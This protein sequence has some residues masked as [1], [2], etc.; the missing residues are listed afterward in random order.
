M[1]RLKTF[2]LKSMWGNYNFDFAC[3]MARGRSGGLISMRDPNSFIKDDI[4]CDDTFIIVK[5][6][7]RNTVG[8]CYM[9]NIYGPQ[10]SLA[11]A[12]LWNRIGD[13]MHQ[14]AD[15][16][17]SF[18]D[19]SGLTDLPL[20]G[21]EV[22][23]ALLDVRVT[24]IDRLWS[25]HNLILLHVSKS[26]FGPTPFKLFH[27]L[28]L[29]DSFD[30]VIKIELSKLEEHNFGRKLLS[31]EK[32]R[33]LKVRKKRWHSET[34][35][36]DRVTKHD[37]LQLI[38][39][40]E[41]KIKAGSAN[42]DDYDSRIKLLQEVDILDTFESFDLLKKARVKWDIEGD[43]DSKFF[44]G[45]IKQKRIAQMIHERFKE[46]DLNVDFPLFVNSSGLCTLD[47]NSL[48]T[49]VSLDEVKNAV[50]DYGSSK[51]PSPDGFLFTFVKKY[52]DY[53][54][55]DIWSMSIFFLILVCCPMDLI[56]ISSLSFQRLAKVIDKIIDGPLILSEI[57][58]WFQKK[59]KK[60]LI[61]KIDFE[62]A[63]DS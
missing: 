13:F 45:L 41:E 49:H 32:F 40:I 47:R 12:I 17:N 22:A 44:H 48:E 26:D 56:L 36:S 8:D 21:Q 30:E 31:H 14:H 35:T 61:F 50:W 57:V 53:I 15:N 16:F 29:R 54:K 6:H 63:F 43:E 60:L 25:D 33:L 27:S 19:N 18:I 34:K 55:V 20:G 23:K 4:W 7:W 5:G 46:H 37:N 24:A 11:K 28:L 1:T 10:D 52:W 3:S 62:K 51:A 2:R 9:I 38:K 58:E 39:S 59:K 42:D